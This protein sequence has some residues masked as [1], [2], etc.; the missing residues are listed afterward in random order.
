VIAV[1]D[2]GHRHAVARQVLDEGEGVAP[3]HVRVLHPWRMCTGQPV[4]MGFGPMSRCR[5]PSSINRAG[6]RVRLVRIDGR[7]QVHAF[8]VDRATDVFREALPHQPFREVRGGRDQHQ[9]CG[10]TPAGPAQGPGGEERQPP[11]HGRAD[12]DRPVRHMGAQDRERVLEPARDGALLEAPARLAVAGVVEAHEA[13]P[14]PRRPG[15]QRLGLGG[16]HVGAEA[17]EPDD[18]RAA[19]VAHERGEPARL[20][21]LA[22]V[23]ELKHCL[24]VPKSSRGDLSGSRFVGEGCLHP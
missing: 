24:T 18:G 20:G 4:A 8:G 2:E 14:G 10:R 9:P 17:A 5:R 6:D 11:A 15:I 19:A 16:P 23:H 12:E 13:P 3:R 21:A 22:D 7:L 1:L